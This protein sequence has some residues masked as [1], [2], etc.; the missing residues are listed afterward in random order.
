MIRATFIVFSLIFLAGCTTTAPSQSFRPENYKGPAM[1]IGG[2][3]NYAE[4]FNGTLYIAIDGNT[5][6]QS[7]LPMNANN[8]QHFG[9]YKEHRIMAQFMQGSQYGI[10]Q[11][12]ANVFVDGELAA[13]LTFPPI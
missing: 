2:S 12:S 6:I 10:I 7:K 3:V 9:N 1:N 8:T 4:G 11:A 13:T 5:I